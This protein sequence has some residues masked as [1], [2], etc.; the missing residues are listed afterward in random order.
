MSSHLPPRGRGHAFGSNGA[1]RG[2]AAPNAPKKQPADAQV[3]VKV[4]GGG[5]VH[6]VDPDVELVNPNRAVQAVEEQVA[7]L[8]LP[9][10]AEARDSERQRVQEKATR[11]ARGGRGS[12]RGG[13]SHQ[14]GHGDG[15]RG[16]Q[17]GRGDGGRGHSGA[18]AAHGGRGGKEHAA[19]DHRHQ[20]H[21]SDHGTG[22]AAPPPPTA[23]AHDEPL[24]LKRA[25]TV[26]VE[27]RDVVAYHVGSRPNI[28]A[29]VRNGTIVIGVLK[30]LKWTTGIAFVR[31]AGMASDVEVHSVE[32]RGEALDGDIVAVELSPED[33]WIDV[34]TG[35]DAD[36][37]DV[38]DM[39]EAR[40]APDLKA[41]KKDPNAKAPTLPDGRTVKHI[42]DD[43]DL[44][45]APSKSRNPV[46]AIY[47][48]LEAAPPAIPAGKKPRGVVVAV[49]EGRCKLLHPSRIADTKP[50]KPQPIN[51]TRY[52]RFRSYDEKYPYI[53]VY[54]RD[55]PQAL[56]EN[57]YDILALVRIRTLATTGLP[58]EWIEK[59]FPRGEVVL[60][61]G[62]A[63]TVEAESRAIA[64]SNSV[65]DSDFTDDVLACVFDSFKVPPADK[66][67]EMGRRD[68]RAE[69]FVCTIDPATARDLDDAISVTKTPG[70]YRVGVHIADVSYFVP[71]NSP[72]DL[73]ARERCTSTYFVERVIPML[74][75]KLCEDYCS[76][77]AGEDKFAFSGVFQ[78][79]NAGEV[80][81]E[82]FGQSV[83]RNRCRMAYED[84]QNI[85]DGDLS[86]D[87]LKI[88]E[89]ELVSEHVTRDALAK[90]VVSSVQL[91]FELASKMRKARYDRG[92]LSLN[93]GKLKFQFEDM[94]SRVAPKGFS[95]ETSK[96]ANW[97]VEEFML[98]ANIRV[99][100][101][102][103]EYLPEC[104]LLRNHPKPDFKK[105]TKF[106]KAAAKH[107]IELSVKSSKGL[108]DSLQKY[109]DDPR[110]DALR[111]MAT[112]Q[113]M[114]AKYI[115]AGEDEDLGHFALATPFYTHF[116][117]PIR[118]YADLVVHR[119]L[120]VALDMERRAGQNGISHG[121][122][123]RAVAVSELEHHSF[124]MPHFE[125]IEITERCNTRKENSR[126]CSDASL[127]MFF[128][129]YLEAIRL[130]AKV[131]PTLDP[132]QRV[133]VS[134][135]RIKEKSFTIYAPEIAADCEIMFNS[136]DQLWGRDCT[137]N[138]TDKTVIIHWG[139]RGKHSDD[140]ASATAA[141]GEAPAADASVAASEAQGAV[142]R[143]DEAIDLFSTGIAEL[144]VG[145]ER[146]LLKLLM[147]LLPPEARQG[148][149][150]GV[151]RQIM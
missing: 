9:T 107:G 88:H 121:D 80:V 34:S 52:Y 134:V 122:A 45:A 148:A 17:G 150:V 24:D 108:N 94:N 132:V 89:A 151:L 12:G 99:A 93:K 124:Y 43:S 22:T 48:A 60:S 66:L 146:G 64:A 65:K 136:Q 14:G 78:M 109:A 149:T 116:T 41:S 123:G 1:G 145:H 50:E 86:G 102:I 38:S 137:Y 127:K 37:V 56:H 129:L 31:V 73:E 28:E 59:R 76:L 58:E 18:H 84:A 120:L 27:H 130:R 85:I 67:R 113:M 131:D 29:G 40:L 33:A 144:R 21:R 115:S 19:A 91:M 126:K 15:G 87:S 97:M 141:T 79:N 133:Q 3:E 46:Q 13:P 100:E 147:I 62:L 70:G 90:Q 95:L 135:V 63:N 98:L 71:I 77:N 106:K 118:R 110:S 25:A 142:R 20:Q 103:T 36:V 47:S 128:C 139:P 68:L 82:W 54:G 5:Q 75:H 114:L 2:G 81:G 32:A 51:R 39:N 119:Q 8:G 83:I 111:L 72:L 6:H 49:V 112:Y 4:V 53:A 69:E 138:S 26:P 117:S 10:E 57:L 96:E 7:R 105:L 35:G 30:V 44:A 74:P 11:G 23:V 42:L 143:S 92:A 55:I 101:K 61:L 16:H 104:A 140:S 125:I